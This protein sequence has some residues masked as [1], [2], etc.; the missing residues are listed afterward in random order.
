MVVEVNDTKNESG[1]MHPRREHLFPVL[2]SN[3]LTALLLRN[4]QMKLPGKLCLSFL[5]AVLMV[6]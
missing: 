6:A 3:V 5:I 4:N 2:V 1:R